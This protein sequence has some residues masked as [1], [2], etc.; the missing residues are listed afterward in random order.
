MKLIYSPF[1]LIVL[2]L[3][4]MSCDDTSAD[5]N[6]S[7]SQYSTINNFMDTKT[8]F[9]YRLTAD[10]VRT[11][12]KQGADPNE[13]EKIT[14]DTPLMRAERGDV[15]RA[16]I[17]GGAD[18]HAVDDFGW[19]VVHCMAF[20]QEPED[21]C[22]RTVIDEACKAGLSL[23][24]TKCVDSPL[25]LAVYSDAEP[26]VEYLLARGANPHALSSEEGIC[27]DTCTALN[28][29]VTVTRN[30]IS[31]LL[32]LEAGAKDEKAEKK[33]TPLHRAALAG[34][35]EEVAK[36]L[37]SGVNPD[38][39]GVLECTP[40]MG[41]AMFG[42]MEVVKLLVEAGADIEARNKSDTLYEEPSTGYSVLQLAAWKG[43]TEVIRYLLS[44][45]A[46]PNLAGNRKLRALHIAVWRE[47]EDAVRLLLESGADPNI[48]AGEGEEDWKVSPFFFAQKGSSIYQLLIQYGGKEQ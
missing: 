35:S 19:N 32:L 9:S 42:H 4:G 44:Q 26:T 23:D 45:G 31:T 5:R 3:P 12:I 15:V 38:I 13:H 25:F 11:L 2:Q 37:N 48:L 18:V 7:R 36:L 1:L 46:D 47:K 41:A 20:H 40:L 27:A 14:G 30:T 22:M 6:G 21:D 28:Y 33:W 39:R 29:A 34:D 8:L 24:G 10:D 16:L 17:E 43:Q